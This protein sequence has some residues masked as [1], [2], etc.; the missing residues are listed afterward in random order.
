MSNSSNISLD[1]SGLENLIVVLEKDNL[2]IDTIIK[3]T[4]KAIRTLDETKWKSREKD[5]LDEKLMPFI[6][7]AEKNALT[8]LNASTNLLRDINKKYQKDD[9]LMSKQIDQI[10]N[11]N[12]VDVL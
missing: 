9:E 8:Y 3:E 7:K 4:N 10:I 6:D 2:E 5:R 11:N 1:H 12:Q